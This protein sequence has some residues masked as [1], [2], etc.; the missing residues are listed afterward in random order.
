MTIRGRSVGENLTTSAVD[1]YVVPPNFVADV[2]MIHVC[3]KTNSTKTVTVQWYEAATT[4][5][6]SLLNTT[7][8]PSYN[9]IQIDKPLILNAGDKIIGLASANA[10][11]DLSIR[12]QEAYTPIKM[13]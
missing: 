1:V 8:V 2:E 12:L 9:F 6:H 7:D 11:V 13:S 4:H 3:N 5:T 10:S